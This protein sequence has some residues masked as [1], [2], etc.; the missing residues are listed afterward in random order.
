MD[1]KNQNFFYIT[2]VF[3]QEPLNVFRYKIVETFY[4]QEYLIVKIIKFVLVWILFCYLGLIIS[5][6]YLLGKAIAYLSKKKEVRDPYTA[7]DLCVVNFNIKYDEL[8]VDQDHL[9]F[10]PPP[11]TDLE[12]TDDEKLI[13]VKNLIEIYKQVYNRYYMPDAFKK[14][15]QVVSSNKSQLVN[16]YHASKTLLEQTSKYLK[17]FISQM[18]TDQ[19]DTDTKKRY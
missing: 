15:C 10:A 14:L 4:S 11:I 19:V 2:G 16:R 13:D 1:I 17:F 3:L 18:Q 6:S 9:H 12:L 8:R 7:P 5:A